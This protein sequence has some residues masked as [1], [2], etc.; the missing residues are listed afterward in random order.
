MAAAEENQARDVVAVQDPPPAKIDATVQETQDMSINAKR[1]SL[2]DIF[3][4]VCRN[5]SSINRV[6]TNDLRRFVLVSPSSAMA[7]RTT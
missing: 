6:T 2:S 5:K 4:I 3:T 7:T 1:Q